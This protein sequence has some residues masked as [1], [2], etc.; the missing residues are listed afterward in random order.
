[1]VS[2]NPY[3]FEEGQEYEFTVINRLNLPPDDDTYFVRVSSFQT[4]HLLAEKHYVNYKIMPGQK[5]KCRIDKINCSG[6]IF[7][8]PEHPCYKENAVYDFPVKGIEEISNSEGKYEKM[9]VVEDCWKNK[10]CIH[11]DGTDHAFDDII[12]CRVDRIKKGKLYLTPVSQPRQS[13]SYEPGKYYEFRIQDIVTLAEGEEYYELK[14]ESDNSH[15]LRIK[16]YQNYQ[17]KTGDLV[18]CCYVAAPALF[19]HYLEPLHP[20]YHIGSTYEF[21]CTGT[22]KVKNVSGSEVTLINVSDGSD[23]DYFVTCSDESKPKPETGS[24]I[25]CLLKNIK[26]GRLVLEC[27]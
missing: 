8:E 14:D 24:V 4:R 17:F 21:I 27:V 9:L 20:F 22:T 2:V 18:R 7:L 1:M 23:K 15:Y 26:M 25:R 10:V 16:Y 13:I 6:K 3:F 19:R 5:V 12:Q 11:I